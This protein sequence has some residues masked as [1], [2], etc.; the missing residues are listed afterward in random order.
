MSLNFFVLA[1]LE[2]LEDGQ[3]QSLEKLGLVCLV[4]ARF[5]GLDYYC[6]DCCLDAIEA[7]LTFFSD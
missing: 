1:Q 2:Q 3:G 5:V 4:D 7:L 6:V